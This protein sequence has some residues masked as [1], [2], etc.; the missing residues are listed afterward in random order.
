MS[1]L[2]LKENYR[3]D[4]EGVEFAIRERIGDP[5]DFIGR[6]EELEYLY[7]WAGAVQR[8]LSRSIAFL[9]RRKVG[10][11]LMLE[12][13]YN[14]LYSEQKGLLPFYYEFKEG[15]RSAKKFYLDFIVR[16]Y[17]Q[18]VGYY[19][20]DVLLI[21]KAIDYKTDVE[22]DVLNE[23]VE[24]EP[25]PN[26]AIIL[27]H[28]SRCRYMMAAD[29]P[30]YEYVLSAVA[31]PDA[32]A[33][34]PGVEERIVQMIDEFQY[35]NMFIDAG[36]EKKPCKAYMGTAESRV[37]P[38]LIT[39]SLMGIVS[40]ELMRWL[41]HRFSQMHVPKM[42]PH[43]AQAMTLNYGHL[44]G[45][46]M[47]PKIAEYIVYVTNG[48]PGRIVELLSPKIGKPPITTTE[49][50]DIALEYETGLDGGIKHDWDEYLELAMDAVNDINMRRI[51]YFL[52]KHEGEWYYPG[53]LK[54]AMNLK[55]E[56][57]PLRKELELLY[58]YDIVELK[59][60]RYGGV[61]DRTLKKVLMS[62]YADILELPVD[63]FD[64]YFKSDSLLDYLKERV[65]QL[66]LSLAEMRDVKQKLKVLQNT[67]N[68]VK[69]HQ[70]ELETL[71]RLLKGIIDGDGGLVAG[72]QVTTVRD[73]LNY[74]LETGEEL[75]IVLEGE[76]AIVMVECKNYIPENLDKITTKMV[77]DFV[78]KATRLHAS[79]FAD[80]E[81]RLGFFSKHGF[82]KTLETY[83][84]QRGIVFTFS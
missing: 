38:L 57:T 23:Q 24:T 52:C 1:L 53:E 2:R 79:H 13:L 39:G 5:A 54:T 16:F 80:K 20:R 31:T 41:P 25:I 83:L 69:G 18:V 33:K 7:S 61:F 56:E 36:V 28:L 64:A 9:G 70:Y 11:S 6:V 45:Y 77:D 27:D 4:L 19:T 30:L 67:H 14:I 62:N 43:E 22:L 65:Q 26:K 46:S 35:L 84:T 44:H 8:G 78:D 82:E 37:A 72:M 76:P 15:E 40:E 17:M 47:T 71:L 66:E 29:E 63:E 10:K 21:R 51:T 50:V 68:T 81:L 3:W 59:G 48:V 58:K 42:N 12:R 75:D 32:F 34:T 55:I 74:H 73:V 60:G 49:N